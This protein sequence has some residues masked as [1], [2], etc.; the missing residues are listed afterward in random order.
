MIDHVLLAMRASPDW[1]EFA[2]DHAA[3]ITVSPDR[4]LPLDNPHF[5]RD[6]GPLI[7]RWNQFSNISYFVCRKHI[8]DIAADSL[9]RIRDTTLIRSTDVPQVLERLGD[10]Q[11]LLFYHDDDDWFHP[12]LVHILRGL[13]LDAASFDVAVFPFL[14]LASN[15]V[16]FTNDGL[17]TASALGSYEPFRFR[18]CTNNYGLTRRAL[19]TG[20]L[21]LVEHIDACNR[22][23]A[24]EFADTYCDVIVSATSKTPCSAS[25]LHKL[26]DDLEAFRNY[27]QAYVAV[28][29]R[30]SA[31]PAAYWMETELQKTIS[32][33]VA[34]ASHVT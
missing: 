6:I 28:L 30:F 23:T 21:E 8:R 19:A 13:A 27:V 31:S 7:E 29:R 17:P 33:F 24:L 12:E 15:M 22:A 34:C 25:W 4:Y 3:G 9:S 32:L 14:R 1:A 11:C 5:P 18:Y 10:D 26:P 16:T 20:P 2:R